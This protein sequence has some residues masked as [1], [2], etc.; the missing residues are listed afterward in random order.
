MNW[1]QW[2]ET[3][4]LEREGV[5]LWEPSKLPPYIPNPRQHVDT[6]TNTHFQP[7]P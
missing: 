1:A 6:L 4:R 3:Q 2:S 5:H 7:E